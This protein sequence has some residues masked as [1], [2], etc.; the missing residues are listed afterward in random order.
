MARQVRCVASDGSAVLDPQVKCGLVKPSTL[1]ACNTNKCD[2]CAEASRGCSGHG[3]C[4]NDH[5]VCV[6][7]YKGQLCDTAADCNGVRDRDDACCTSPSVLDKFG[8][9]CDGI[10]DGQGGC[11]P[12]PSTVDNCGVCRAPGTVGGI[13]FDIL[14]ACCTSSSAGMVAAIGEDGLCC[15]TGVFDTCGVCDGDSSSCNVA[16]ST[17][18]STASVTAVDGVSGN[19]ATIV[20]DVQPQH[21]PLP[22]ST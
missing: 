1:L 7:G 20:A 6:S 8:L 5:C 11:C 4:A 12:T 17:T 13:G 2:W 3:D 22:S 18:F 16:A 9:C 21:S 14:G 19:A 10:L 15:P